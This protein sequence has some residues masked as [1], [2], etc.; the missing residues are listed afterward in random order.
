M[1]NNYELIHSVVYQMLAQVH[2]GSFSVRFYE[3]SAPG[4][5]KLSAVSFSLTM[6]V[7]LVCAG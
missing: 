6:K 5:K 4:N 2:T 1:C 7:C 3:I